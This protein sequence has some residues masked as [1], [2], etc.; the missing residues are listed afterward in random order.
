MELSVQ[1]TFQSKHPN[2]NGAVWRSLGYRHTYHHDTS[3]GR[4]M[5]ELTHLGTNSQCGWGVLPNCF[6]PL[7]VPL[8]Y[9]SV[10]IFKTH[11]RNTSAQ[12]KKNLTQL[13][14][15][16]ALEREENLCGPPWGGLHAPDP[17]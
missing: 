1:Q 2:N 8:Q 15:T 14:W 13:E 12:E 7:V 11:N 17:L 3:R 16:A 4:G 6:L 9:S 10:K 5:L